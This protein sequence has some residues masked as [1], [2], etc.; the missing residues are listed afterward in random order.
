MDKDKKKRILNVFLWATPVLILVC[1][2]YMR[3]KSPDEF[4]DDIAIGIAMFWLGYMT[5]EY[6]GGS[7]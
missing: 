6:V 5:S 1:G 7:K 3:V 2:V 4:F